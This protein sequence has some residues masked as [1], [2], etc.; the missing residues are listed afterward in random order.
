MPIIYVVSDNNR[1]SAVPA[2]ERAQGKR[3]PGAVKS[4]I[5]VVIEDREGCSTRRTRP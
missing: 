3:H 4:H 2:F 1:I 5:P